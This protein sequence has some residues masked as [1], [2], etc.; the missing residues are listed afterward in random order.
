MY[1]KD[2][3][4]CFATLDYGDLIKNGQIVFN[5]FYLTI[6]DPLYIPFFLRKIKKTRSSIKPR[7]YAK[8]NPTNALKTYFSSIFK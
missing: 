6:A 2:E 5:D 7:A 1:A 8:A 3:H 4:L